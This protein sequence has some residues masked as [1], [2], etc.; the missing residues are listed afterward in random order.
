[1]RLTLLLAMLALIWPSLTLPARPAAARDGS[2]DSDSAFFNGKDLSG[3]EGIREYWSVQ[4]GAIVG[5]PPKDPGYNN[6]LCSKKKYRDFELSFQVRIKDGKG[7]SGV[8]IRSKLLDA[9]KYVVGGPQADIGQAFWGSLYGEQFDKGH[10]PG[11]P[12]FRGGAMMKQSP[13]KVVEKVKQ[14]E[15]NDYS[16][17]CVGKHVVIKVNGEATVDDDFP[18]MPDEGILA[19]QLHTGYGAMEVTFKDI[20]F[21]DLSKGEK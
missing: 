16:I 3:W 11:E 20:H 8:Q 13:K 7:N 21:K 14:T 6:F 1:M 9:R 17:R 19:L 15:F 12:G 4:D 10:F 18:M 5:H 2:A